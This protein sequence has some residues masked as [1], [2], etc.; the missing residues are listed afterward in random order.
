MGAAIKRK[1]T[2]KQ[3]KKHIGEET[4]QYTQEPNLLHMEF[5]KR[6]M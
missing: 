4:K 2:N 6:H 1:Q 3:K 5:G